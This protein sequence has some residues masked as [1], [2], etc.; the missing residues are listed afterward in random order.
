MFNESVHQCIN[1]SIIFNNEYF[2]NIIFYEVFVLM[3]QLA[4][5]A[6]S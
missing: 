1:I 3:S 2:M 4:G 5:E 6:L